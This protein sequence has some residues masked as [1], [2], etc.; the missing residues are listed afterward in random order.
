M[1]KK[2]K[3]NI[4]VFITSLVLLLLAYFIND[5]EFS[6]MSN[7]TGRNIFIALVMLIIGIYLFYISI[8]SFIVKKISTK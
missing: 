2:S 4:I 5:R 8:S 1:I 3:G 7:M 6:N